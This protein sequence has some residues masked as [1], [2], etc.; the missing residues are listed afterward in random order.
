MNGFGTPGTSPH[1]A[2]SRERIASARARHG[3]AADT[4]LEHLR[5]GDPLVD[6]LVERF[7][8]MPG[9]KGYRTLMR[10][11]D[12]GI[13]SVDDPTDELVALFEQLDQVPMWVD[14]DRMKMGSAKILQNALLPAM[15]LVVYALPQ[16]YFATGNKPLV[17]STSLIR[18][19]AQRYAATTRFFTEVFMPGAMRRHADGFKFVVLTR[20]YHARVRRQILRSGKWDPSLGVPLNQAHMA[21]GTIILSCLV[22]DGMR[23]LGGRIRREEM[24]G[25]TLIWRY[26]G[27]LFGVGAP[28]S[29]TSEAEARRLIE[30]GYS[31]EF[32]ADED[33]RRLCNALV[34]ATPEILKIRNPFLARTLVSILFALSRKLLGDG[35]ADRLGYPKE[36]RR[37]LCSLGTSLAWI[38]E[39]FPVLIPPR[40][41]R[42]MGVSF[43]LEQGDY[44]RTMYQA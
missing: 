34:H 12:S 27:Y 23:R 21:M 30:V 38:F 19:T 43:W 36:K 24:E 39:R 17:F 28:M 18:K 26:V 31:L 32:D 35:V 9:R 11:L 44:D 5:I 2:L 3:D 14:W 10:A 16:S 33:A 6:G 29:F 20:V 41:R 13:D 40:L 37:L 22:P 25:I 7:E 4:Y 42:Y 15:S 1:P 8:R